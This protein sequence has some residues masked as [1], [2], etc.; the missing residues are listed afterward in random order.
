MKYF[1]LPLGDMF[2]MTVHM[3][4]SFIVKVIQRMQR[5]NCG[6]YMKASPL[7]RGEISSSQLTEMKPEYDIFTVGKRYRVKCTFSDGIYNFN[8]GEVLIFKAWGFVPYYSS[9]GYQF[10]SENDAIDA[11]HMRLLRQLKPHWQ[12][13]HGRNNL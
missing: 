12:M 5:I 13:R 7:K 9:Y 11:R 2:H 6:D 1:Y 10:H 4:T 8:I 3:D